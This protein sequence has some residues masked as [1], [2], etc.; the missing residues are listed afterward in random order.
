MSIAAPAA[1]SL[2]RPIRR[3]SLELRVFSY[4]PTKKGAV[5][6]KGYSQIKCFGDQSRLM[7]NDVAA[8][9]QI[10]REGRAADQKNSRLK[11]H[12]PSVYNYY[13]IVTTQG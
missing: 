2:S 11:R 3:Q 7:P 4:G 8:P 12:K 6:E 5:T 1:G 9:V 13:V 10:N